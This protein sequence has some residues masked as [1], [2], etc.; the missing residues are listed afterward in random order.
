MAPDNE[1][2]GLGRPEIYPGFLG[3]LSSIN[4]SFNF[5]VSGSNRNSPPSPE[6][7]LSFDGKQKRGLSESRGE[8]WVVWG[9]AQW[10]R[11]VLQQGRGGRDWSDDGNSLHPPPPIQACKRIFCST[12]T[13]TEK[14][15][16]T[17]KRGGG[18]IQTK[19]VRLKNLPAPTCPE[20]GNASE[21]LRGSSGPRLNSSGWT[22]IYRPSLSDT[23]EKGS[24]PFV[25]GREDNGPQGPGSLG[26]LSGHAFLLP[27]PLC[28]R[29][30]Q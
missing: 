7:M 17:K 28:R 9:T 14:R 10:G 25:F 2:T 5:H 3:E 26:T 16:A 20:K 29:Q 22:L 6:Q 21:R 12:R 23:L 24:G 11:C 27:S 18:G 4:L 15:K 1:T 30:R 13:R 19:R 8:I